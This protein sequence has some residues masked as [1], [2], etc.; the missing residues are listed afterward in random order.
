M[1]GQGEIKSGDY[2]KYYSGGEWAEN[3]VAIVA[4]K[5]VVRNVVKKI[6][7]TDRIIS[8]KLQA[9]L[10]NILIVQ[11]YMATLEY[12]D[13]EVE[14]LYDITEEI[15]EGYGKGNRNTIIMGD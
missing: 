15:L 13:D 4:H 5:S 2:T 12:G 1:K 14:M 8:I 9:E 10:I 6:G 3:G 7:Y 11:V